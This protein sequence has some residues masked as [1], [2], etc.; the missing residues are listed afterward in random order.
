MNWDNT[1]LKQSQWGVLRKKNTIPFKK[2][3]N[4]KITALTKY[5][6]KVFLG[7]HF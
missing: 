5:L 6:K 3:C 1:I 2:Y 7:I 4:Y